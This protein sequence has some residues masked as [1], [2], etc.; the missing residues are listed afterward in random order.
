MIMSIVITTPTGNIGG[1]ALQ[2]LLKAGADISVIVRRPE[3]LSDSVRSRVKIH[4][5]SLSDQALVKKAFQG[6]KAVL[7]V[8]PTDFTQPDVASYHNE[9]GSIAASAVKESKVPYVVHIS[10]VGAQ[11]ENAGPVSGVGAV[12]GHLNGVVENVVHLRPGFFME[13]FLMDLESIR[14][15][16][17][18]YYPLPGDVPFPMIATQDIGDVAADLLLKTDWIGQQTRGLHG[19]EDLTFANA[20]QILGETIGTP[21]THVQITPDQA[22]QAF[23]D[24]GASPG[25]AKAYVEMYQALTQP[26]AVAEIRTPQTTTPTTLREWGHNIFR[27]LITG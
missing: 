3:K 23:L 7:W 14:K 15:D 18:A 12:E 16:G 11:L 13:N 8:T 10:S 19:P 20:A 4:Q 27:P 1:R 5:G 22:R 26:G 9:M 6:A 21:V 2:Q 17:A 25:F 24:F